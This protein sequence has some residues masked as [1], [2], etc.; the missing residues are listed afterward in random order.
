MKTEEMEAVADNYLCGKKKKTL[1]L[2]KTD[3]NMIE[4]GQLASMC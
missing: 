1:T 4:K 2:N 3:R